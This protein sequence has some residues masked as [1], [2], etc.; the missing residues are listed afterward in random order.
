MTTVIV[1]ATFN[2][3]QAYDCRIGRRQF[4][5]AQGGVCLCLAQRIYE[6]HA[7]KPSYG[8]RIRCAG[9]ETHFR[10]LLGSV[11]PCR[12]GRFF[13]AALTLSLHNRRVY[14]TGEPGTSGEPLP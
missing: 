3:F 13:S 8:W 4:I 1:A 12:T 5:S 2:M 11:Q 10:S 7:G 14:I 9:V 6:K